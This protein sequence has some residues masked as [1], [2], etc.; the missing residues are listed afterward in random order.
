MTDQLP[1]TDI[2]RPAEGYNTR[3]A[4]AGTIVP[5]SWGKDIESQNV[6]LIEL[7]GDYARQFNQLDLSVRGMAVDLRLIGGVQLIVITL[8][9]HINADLFFSFCRSVISALELATDPANAF[10]ITSSQIMRWRTFL[11]GRK[12]RKLSDEEVRGLFGELWILRQV[13]AFTRDPSETVSAWCGPDKVHQDFIFRD[14]AIETKA[15]SGRERNSVRISSEDQLE[16]LSDRLYLVVLRLV[17]SPEHG[18]HAHSLNELVR[19]IES[20]IS[21]AAA[22]DEFG[23][24]ISSI[25]YFE[26]PDYDEPAFIIAGQ[27]FYRV[28]EGFPRLVRSSLPDGLARLNYDVQLEAIESFK[29]SDKEV[30]A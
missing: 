4:S 20:E 26:L 18:P 3:R 16:A 28:V 8:D 27:Q 17:S 13:L 7:D 9:E 5:V 25:G 30:W 23:R 22:L 12:S 24:K 10:S 21:D 2:K 29:C 15:I 14:I 11:S 1:W 19:I 6:L